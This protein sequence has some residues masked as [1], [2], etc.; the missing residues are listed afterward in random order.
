MTWPHDERFVE[1]TPGQPVPSVALN[2]IQDKILDLHKKKSVWLPVSRTAGLYPMQNGLWVA[3]EKEA[4]IDYI[5]NLPSLNFITEIKMK[6]FFRGDTVEGSDLNITISKLKMEIE[7]SNDKPQTEKLHGEQVVGSESWYVK[8]YAI[9]HMLDEDEMI[10][11][12]LRNFNADEMIAGVRATY[13]PLKM[14]I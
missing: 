2:E 5:L 9:N 8:T 11:I 3:S 6:F 13:I 14:D 1:F 10:H 12:S 7:K 4:H